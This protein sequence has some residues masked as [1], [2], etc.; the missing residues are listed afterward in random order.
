MGYFGKMHF[1]ILSMLKAL[2]QLENQLASLLSK[3]FKL[4]VREK[5]G[6]TSPTCY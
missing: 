2:M 3:S 4:L 6:F 5:K 1:T